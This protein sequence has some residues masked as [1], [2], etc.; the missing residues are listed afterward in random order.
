MRSGVKD[1]R[2]GGGKGQQQP[3]EAPGLAWGENKSYWDVIKRFPG[4][5]GRNESKSPNHFN[6]VVLFLGRTKQPFSS[7]I[8]F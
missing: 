7:L 8:T 6:Q 2:E 3:R 5:K 1:L 4:Q